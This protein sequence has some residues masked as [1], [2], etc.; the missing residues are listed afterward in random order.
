MHDFIR[1][2]V[3][4]KSTIAV[5][6]WILVFAYAYNLDWTKKSLVQQK[7]TGRTIEEIIATPVGNSAELPWDKD[8]KSSI[9]EIK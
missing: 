9:E 2:L 1:K 4:S 3:N 6:I 5:I 7:P 8:F